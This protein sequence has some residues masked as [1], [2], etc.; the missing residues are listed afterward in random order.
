MQYEQYHLH[1]YAGLTTR[2]SSAKQKQEL[3]LKVRTNDALH[4]RVVIDDSSR[5]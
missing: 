1:V 3:L 2:H 4:Q 5:H